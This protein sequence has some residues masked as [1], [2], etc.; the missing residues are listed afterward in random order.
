MVEFNNERIEEI[1]HKETP[2][3]E[4]LPTILRGIYVR[5]MRLFER[6]F[7]DIDAL[8]DDKVAELRKYHE[9]T[10]G[11]IRHYYMRI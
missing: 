9:E 5:Y 8:D 7:A 2:K 11:L 6:Y 10:K 4:E 1:L 3:T